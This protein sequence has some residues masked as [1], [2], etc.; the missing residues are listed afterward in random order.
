MARPHI[1]PFVDTTVDFKKTRIP[2]FPTGMQYKM[3][4]LDTDTGACSMTVRLEPGNPDVAPI[5]VPA[6]KV[7][8]QGV[9]VGVIRKY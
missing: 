7:Q 4:S 6:E 8:I 1:E 9:V 5:V 3:L 2:G